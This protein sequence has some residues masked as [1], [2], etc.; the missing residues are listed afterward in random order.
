MEGSIGESPDSERA[1]AS[2][3]VAK[4]EE[5]FMVRNGIYFLSFRHPLRN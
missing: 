2:N 3:A 1:P 5:S 4:F